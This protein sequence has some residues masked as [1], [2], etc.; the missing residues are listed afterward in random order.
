MSLWVCAYICV[1]LTPF[2][3]SYY[4]TSLISLRSRI[5]RIT[6]L[7]QMSIHLCVKTEKLCLTYY[8]YILKYNMY[9]TKYDLLSFNQLRVQVMCA[10]YKSIAQTFQPSIKWHW[11]SQHIYTQAILL[12]IVSFVWMGVRMSVSLRIFYFPSL[13]SDLKKTHIIISDSLLDCYRIFP[14]H[15]CKIPHF[16]SW[17]STTLLSYLPFLTESKPIY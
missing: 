8:L 11:Q 5:Y 2:C 15:H 13:A 16:H 1:C 12:L 6:R 3:C 17:S 7:S 10:S 14:E 4:M 9:V